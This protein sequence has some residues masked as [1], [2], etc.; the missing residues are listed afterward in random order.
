[1]EATRGL[2]I[3]KY[4]RNPTKIELFRVYLVKIIVLVK[5]I[6]KMIYNKLVN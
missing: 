6:I 4:M 5:A 3:N 1:M 2:S